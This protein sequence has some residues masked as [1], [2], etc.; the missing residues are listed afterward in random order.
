MYRLDPEYIKSSCST[1]WCNISACSSGRNYFLSLSL[2]WNRWSAAGISEVPHNFSENY[3]SIL[4]KY[5]II[6][7]STVTFFENL[8]PYPNSLNN[9]TQCTVKFLPWI[10]YRYS[11]NFVIWKGYLC[12]TFEFPMF[13]L[14]DI[15]IHLL[16]YHH[17]SVIRVHFKTLS[18]QVL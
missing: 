4:F 13:H 9:F 18:L 17:T 7:T 16:S 1:V 6:D 10:Y 8:G 14:I 2:I 3:S 15:F 5:L 11:A 12:N